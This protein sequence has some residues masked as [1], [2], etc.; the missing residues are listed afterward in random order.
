MVSMKQPVSMV[1]YFKPVL[2]KG[3]RVAL[4][5]LS[6]RHLDDLALA[7]ADEAIWRWLPSA[8]HL[9]GSMATFIQAALAAHGKQTAWPFATVDLVS[10]KA[11][12]STRY[13]HIEPEHRRLEVGVTWLGTEFQR[14][15][16]N[17]EA[18]LLQFWFAFDVLK[19][20]R[21]ELKADI[22]N[23]KSRAAI[24]RLG[25]TQE[26]IFRKHMLYSD[27]RNRDNVYFSVVDDEWPQVR[28]LLE[29]KL[30]YAVKPVFEVQ[31]AA[32]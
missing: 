12:G 25:A 26:G 18:K 23:Q 11:V 21:V 30:G 10:K 13:H 4:E 28:A 32:R 29:A 20:R 22:D 16:I 2:I 1:E 17:T 3:A 31:S 15:H 7:G 9:P 27:G 19:C 24:L 14:S 5:P 8:H 6:P